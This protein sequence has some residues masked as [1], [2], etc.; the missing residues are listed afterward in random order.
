MSIWID[1]NTRL[2][3][4]GMTGK[5]GIFHTRQCVE[6]GTS[7]VAGVTPGKGGQLVDGIP[8]CNTVREAVAETGANTS[9]IFVPPAFAAD[10]ILEA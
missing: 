6:Y 8:V 2:V 4:Q 1:T 10:A 5:E 3:V 9:M 7:V